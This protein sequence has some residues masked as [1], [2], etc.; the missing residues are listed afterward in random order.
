LFHREEFRARDRPLGDGLLYSFLTTKPND[1]VKP[2]Q[3]D[4][5]PFAGS[6]AA[7]ETWM[8]RGIEDALVFQRRALEDAVRIVATSK[9]FD[10]LATI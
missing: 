8:L 1:I 6:V 4:A 9:K 7:R 5:G 3:S 10:G 2:S